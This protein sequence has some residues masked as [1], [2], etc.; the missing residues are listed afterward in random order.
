MTLST[1]MDIATKSDL[2]DILN[3]N[4]EIIKAKD[5]SLTYAKIKNSIRNKLI[6][7][8]IQEDQDWITQQLGF[9]PIDAVVKRENGIRIIIIYPEGRNNN[10]TDV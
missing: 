8:S 7:L 5:L 4:E 3:S 9:T 2:E 6:F 10:G 1:W